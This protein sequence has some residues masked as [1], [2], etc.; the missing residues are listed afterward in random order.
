MQNQELY[1]L[2][3]L[4]RMQGDISRAIL[5]FLTGFNQ[6][7]YQK[8]TISSYQTAEALACDLNQSHPVV[9]RLALSHATFY[10]ENMHSPEF[11]VRISALAIHKA[12]SDLTVLQ[13]V[14]TV[15]NSV[16]QNELIKATQLL[17]ML[18]K[19]LE[20]FKN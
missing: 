2:V 4:N 8:Q 20:T 16:Q 9:L 17:Q 6:L 5:V 18:A 1:S 13:R 15:T 10:F 19:N 7:I 3:L 14:S 11:A 12:K